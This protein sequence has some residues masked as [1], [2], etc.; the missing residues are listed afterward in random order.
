MLHDEDARLL[1]RVAKLAS[2][3]IE[4][5]CSPRVTASFDP[6]DLRRTITAYDFAM[7][8][9]PA[10]VA[11]ELFDLLRETGIRSDNPRYF[12]L[13]N[14]PTLASAI[15]G[16]MIAA[17]VNPQLA[18]WAHAPAAAEVER[19]LVNLFGSRIW[20]NIA[21]AGSF[22]GGGSEANHTALLSAMARR[23]PQWPT[24]GLQSIEQR[25]AIYVSAQ[26]HLAW[27][28]IARSAGLGS[29]AVRLVP[30]TDGMCL[31][32]DVLRK[33]IS[34]EPDYDPVLIV[35]T[36]GTTAHGAIDDLS[37][38]AE[39]GRELDAHI[40]VDAAWA[41]GILLDPAHRHLLDGIEMADS[42]TID[43]HKWLAVPMGAGLYLARGW[44]ALG[45][46]FSVN[47]DYMPKPAGIQPDL[48][49]HSLQWSRRFTGA[50]LF[51]ALA[52]LGL[53]GYAEMIGRQFDLGNY[54]R[55]RL[56]EEGWVIKN[57]TEL[58]LVCFTPPGGEPVEEIERNVAYS[59][60]AWI[61]S[62]LL[63]GEPC[64]RACITSFE[65][66][67]CDIDALIETLRD[68]RTEAA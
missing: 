63:Q 59:G 41:G 67:K 26:S 24:L 14:P 11:S 32:S 21:V 6:A 68:A 27:I 39:V 43:P 33:A 13:F 62:V 35:A 7:P 61:S 66:T 65:T 47:T 22:T 12:G 28:K 5:R 29:E 36:A 30:T 15:A 16:D 51:L 8:R 40:H 58:P 46:A 42:V 3:H 48:Y 52:S 38:I 9:D 23:Y 34:E 37:G 60:N 4:G 45:A 18:V 44:A 49:L 64:L 25:P 54:L 17:T 1:T 2:D 57:S 19:H 20:G 10:E 31:D 50:K 56:A 55:R 53:D